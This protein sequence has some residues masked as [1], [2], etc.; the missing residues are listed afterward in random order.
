MGDDL[1]TRA[2]VHGKD[3]IGQLAQQFN[4]MAERLEASFAA[5]AAELGVWAE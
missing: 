5:L 4:R 2:P 1:S 3:E